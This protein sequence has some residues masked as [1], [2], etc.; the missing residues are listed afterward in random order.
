MATRKDVREFVRDWLKDIEYFYPE[1]IDKA[2][3]S[4]LIPGKTYA[5]TFL[6]LEN[7]VLEEETERL[8]LS[9]EQN[10]EYY[11]GARYFYVRQNG[12]KSISILPEGNTNRNE[13]CLI[14]DINAG[15]GA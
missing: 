14:W 6:N 2:L 1:A 10:E 4:F 5:L 11:I 3:L 9:E 12:R 7:P 8:K 13:I 15:L